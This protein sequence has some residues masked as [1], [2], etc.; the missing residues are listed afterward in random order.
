MALILKARLRQHWWNFINKHQDY[1]CCFQSLHYIISVFRLSEEDYYK[2]L[3]SENGYSNLT[4]V[5]STFGAFQP[6][7]KIISILS[8]HHQE[9]NPNFTLNHSF[10][11]FHKILYSVTILMVM[12][13]FKHYIITDQHFRKKHFKVC[14]L[15]WNQNLYSWCLSIYVFFKLPGFL[16]GRPRTLSH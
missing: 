1:I 5:Y 12:S 13:L 16:M 4:I 14:L 3:L 7:L 9:K 11:A 10:L 8:P 2:T 15:S 6:L